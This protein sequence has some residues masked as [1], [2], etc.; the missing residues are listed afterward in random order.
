MHLQESR[1]STKEHPL[2]LTTKITT[3][4]V[5]VRKMC[6]VFYS[7]MQ[8]TIRITLSLVLGRCCTIRI[9]SRM[10]HYPSR[11]IYAYDQWSTF[12]Y[13]CGVHLGENKYSLTYG[14]Y[15]IRNLGLQ[16]WERLLLWDSSPGDNI[17]SSQFRP[18]G[19][20]GFAHLALL[21]GAVATDFCDLSAT[22]RLCRCEITH[23]VG[24]VS[25][26]GKSDCAV[27]FILNLSD[28][29]RLFNCSWMWR[30]RQ[31]HDRARG[32]S[33]DVAWST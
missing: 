8:N 30:R 2:Q 28:E 15:S 3:S 16:S 29:S 6:Y 31:V 7:N 25:L 13:W 5:H 20:S 14:M 23:D 12:I 4:I 24:F 33:F 32:V 1:H 9:R 22:E 21:C 11:A 27:F 26:G 19:N 10:K 17:N 18:G